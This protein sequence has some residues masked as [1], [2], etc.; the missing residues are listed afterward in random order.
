MTFSEELA[1]IDPTWL[2][3]KTRQAVRDWCPECEPGLDPTK[4]YVT[5]YRCRSHAE[6]SAPGNVDW[7]ARCDQTVF[8]NQGIH[9][10]S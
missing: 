10:I 7:M 5:P 1:G 9:T 6:V 2:A 3:E 8:P 4:E